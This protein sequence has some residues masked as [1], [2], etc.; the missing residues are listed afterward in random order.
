MWEVKYIATFRTGIIN[1]GGYMIKQRLILLFDGTW[2]DP[3]DQTNVFR[4]A[5][6]IRESDGDIRQRFLYDP[7][8]GT[9]KTDRFRG[10]VF[11]YGLS[12]NLLQGYE[13]LAKRYN[14]EDEI[15]IFG[16]SRGAY[17]ARSLVGLIRKCGLLRIVTP[18]LLVRAERIYRDKSASPDCE[19]CKEFRIK[20][21]RA[22]RIHFIGVWDTV[23]A[24][25]IPGT[26][27]SEYG[28]Y[29]WHDTDLSSIVNYAYHAVALDEYRA[30]YDVSLWTSENGRKKPDNLDV[31]QRWFIGAHANVG[32]GY[33]SKDFLADIPLQWMMEKASGAG[34]NLD[35]FVAST[36]AFKTNPEDSFADFL[37]GIY[38][39]YSKL[40]TSGDGKHFRKFNKGMDG[41]P[42]VNVSVDPSVWMRWID[43]EF[44][45]RPR[46]L[47]DA[48][49][50]PPVL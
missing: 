28:E 10:G 11:G 5:G 34:L 30:A 14:S 45:Y 49:Q 3:E 25:G 24:L 4:L 50:Y 36:D 38:A 29:S 22:P 44:N 12:E 46:V 20:F 42:A 16:F 39:W 27:I 43:N 13:W 31:E 1:A 15:W 21:S 47:I 18:D 19:E 40:R 17:T 32:G 6:R 35:E 33:G 9:G 48:G 23:G 26:N 37:K 8:V 41:K 7:G 2:N